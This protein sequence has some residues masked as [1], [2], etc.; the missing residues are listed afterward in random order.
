MAERERW[1]FVAEPKG[2]AYRGLIE[3]ALRRCC[4][5][6]LL[7]VRD[8]EGLARLG[9]QTLRRL[10]SSLIAEEESLEWPGTALPP[11]SKPAR[12]LRYALGEHS[13]DVLKQQAD[14]L[15]GWLHPELPEDLAFLR[16]RQEPWLISVARERRAWL[17]GSR[18][19][20]DA[21]VAAVPGL[22]ALLADQP[23]ARA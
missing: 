15:Y 10:S 12:V 19:G 1:T 5:E 21:L 23:A 7:V 13:A 18:A 4:P 14:G 8:G 6:F 20:R 2:E 22:A 11:L 9:Q 3:H 17:A 16:E